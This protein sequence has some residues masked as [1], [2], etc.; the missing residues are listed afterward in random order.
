MLFVSLHC[1]RQVTRVL[2]T[3]VNPYVKWIQYPFPQWKADVLIGQEQKG[4]DILHTQTG[5]EPESLLML[6]IFSHL[7]TQNTIFI[8]SAGN[9]HALSQNDVKAKLYMFNNLEPSVV[10][11][12][13]NYSVSLRSEIKYNLKCS[14]QKQAFSVEAKLPVR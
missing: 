6:E 11:K 5:T 14:R 4:L 10:K 13:G 2:L 7:Q 9:I 3:P 1:L 12:K 8:I